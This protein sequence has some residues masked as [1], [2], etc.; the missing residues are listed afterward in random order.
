MSRPALT[1]LALLS[2]TLGGLAAA[3]SG[4]SE[5]SPRDE[6]RPGFS[7]EGQVLVITHDERAGLDGWYQQT[8]TV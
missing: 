4:W 5:Q 8:F 3:P 1:L 2:W 6:L 7:R